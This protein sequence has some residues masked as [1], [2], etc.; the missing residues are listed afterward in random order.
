MEN[1]YDAIFSEKNRIKVYHYVSVK[2]IEKKATLEENPFLRFK[3]IITMLL[4]INLLKSMKC[5]QIQFI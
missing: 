5:E 2:H 3:K 1:T 4:W